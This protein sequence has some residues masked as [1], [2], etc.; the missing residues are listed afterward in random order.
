MWSTQFRKWILSETLSPKDQF[1]HGLL[2]VAEQ[3]YAAVVSLRNKA[4]DLGLLPS[5][6]VPVPVISIGN[7]T[8]GGTGKTPLIIHLCRAVEQ[9]GGTPAIVS[10]GYGVHRSKGHGGIS[11]DEALEIATEL[12]R[13]QHIQNRDR[14]EAALQLIRDCPTI[15]CVFMDDGFQHRKLHRDLDIVLIDA[16]APFGGGHLLPRGLLRESLRGLERANVIILTR[17]HQVTPSRRIELRGLLKELAPHADFCETAIVPKELQ[18]SSGACRPV[19]EIKHARVAA[20]AGIG[21]PEAFRR[22]L[23]DLPCEVVAFREFPD[24]HPFGEHDQRELAGWLC[25]LKMID[26]VLCTR[27]DLVKVPTMKLGEIPLWGLKTEIEWLSGWQPLEARLKSLVHLNP[28]S[29]SK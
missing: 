25:Q 18:N 11:N 16:T 14:A 23:D 13:V 7:L 10:R 24:H 20:F 27:K 2:A 19:A 22:T 8:V 6:R 29:D 26:A 1:L 9:M 12:P 17:V 15:H 28:S 21:N 4:F 3:P 5:R